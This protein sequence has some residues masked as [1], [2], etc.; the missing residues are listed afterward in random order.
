VSSPRLRSSPLLH[1]AAE[2]N[3]ITAVLAA[4]DAIAR[5]CFDVFL[6]SRIFFVDPEMSLFGSSVG[7]AKKRLW[8]IDSSIHE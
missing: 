1:E 6:V 8:A 4:I 7:S 5:F 2:E 3:S